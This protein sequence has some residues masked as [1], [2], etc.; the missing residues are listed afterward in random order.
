[1]TP[2]ASAR[3]APAPAPAAATEARRLSQAVARGDEEAF[4][5]L[6]DAYSDRLLRLALVLA[7]GDTSLARDVAQTVWL[8]AA[9]KMKPLE[10]DA[11]LW[12]WLALV[13]RQQTAKALRH[14]PGRAAEV[15]L[16][17][18]PDRPAPSEPDPLLAECLDAA[19]QGL[20]TE[21]RRLIE[22]FY[23]ERLTCEH[24]AT[25]L[26]TTAKAV[27]SRLERARAK[28]RSLVQRRLAHET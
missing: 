28:L 5:Q 14:A 15:S 23:F 9:R 21:D 25:R 11:H 4:R 22:W 12:N 7:R 13:T 10:S 27:S 6:Y 3:P 16:A 19:V 24:I 2:A 1:M 18:L 26:G 20:E 17:E 8:T